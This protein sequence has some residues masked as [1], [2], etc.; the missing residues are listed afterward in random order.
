MVILHETS[1]LPQLEQHFYIYES[2]SF[3][4]MQ[5]VIACD[6]EIK[7]NRM[8]VIQTKL[9]TLGGESAQPDEPSILRVPY[10]NDK[11]VRYTVNKSGVTT[12]I[13]R[14]L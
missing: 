13:R 1:L 7:A 4:L 10:D 12:Y 11:W 14:I 5:I 3:V 2:S 8:A 6:E 9:V